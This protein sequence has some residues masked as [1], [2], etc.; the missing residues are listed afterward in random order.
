MV[1]PR[2]V[3][4]LVVRAV[5]GRVSVSMRVVL[6]LVVGVVMMVLGL[7][8]LFLG[9]WAVHRCE[10]LLHHL[11]LLTSGRLSSKAGQVRLS[12][13]M[14]QLGPGSGGRPLSLGLPSLVSVN[15]RDNPNQ[16]KFQSLNNQEVHV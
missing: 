11:R 16:K 2:V 8:H 14:D 5:I 9:W 7:P 3:M 6:G 12:V 10:V 13:V 1:W 15:P 4:W